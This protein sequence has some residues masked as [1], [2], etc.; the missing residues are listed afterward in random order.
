[1]YIMWPLKVEVEKDE[2]ELIFDDAKDVNV[3]PGA[4]LKRSSKL[5]TH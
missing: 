3:I 4:F 5:E 2:L 1:M